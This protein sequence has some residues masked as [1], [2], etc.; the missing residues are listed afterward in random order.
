MDKCY[1]YFLQPKSGGTFPFID[2]LMSSVLGF[3]FSTAYREHTKFVCH[4]RR[5]SLLKK[6]GV[7]PS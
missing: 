3:G 5:N 1:F 2:F 4:T 7:T 6:E